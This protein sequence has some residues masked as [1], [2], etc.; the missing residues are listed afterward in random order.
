MSSF[1]KIDLWSDFAAGVYLSKAQSPML[2][3]LHTVYV[4]TVHILIH[5]EGQQFTKLGRKYKHDCMYLQ[6][7]KSDKHLR[8]SP[9][10][11]YFF[12]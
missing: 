11:G 6:S 7:I 3:P 12:K 9:F 8:E 1:K 4:H 10:T 5:T 2:P